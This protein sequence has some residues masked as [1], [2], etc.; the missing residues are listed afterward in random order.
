VSRDAN[1]VTM[2]VCIGDVAPGQCWS[3]VNFNCGL[4]K[5]APDDT[6]LAAAAIACARRGAGLVNYT[7]QTNDR[8]GECGY[9]HV[10]VTCSK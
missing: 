1:P 8:G 6:D 2:Q 7:R 5:A 9:I 4:A 3:P 10:S